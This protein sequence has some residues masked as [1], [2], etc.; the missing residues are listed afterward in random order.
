MLRQFSAYYDPKGPAEG[1]TNVQAK[2]WSCR[3]TG[4]VN[5]NWRESFMQ[6]QFPFIQ[7]KGFPQYNPRDPKGN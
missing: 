2:Q 3:I 1:H 5:V 4:Y 6:F 7:R